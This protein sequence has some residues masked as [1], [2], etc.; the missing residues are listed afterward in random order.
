MI[1]IYKK[2]KKRNERKK[3]E[4]R[5][6][7]AGNNE[8][9]VTLTEDALEAQPRVV[10]KASETAP[11]K[12]DS[13]PENK[14][15]K[16]KRRVYRW[17]LIL[18]L[19]G[20]F[21]LQ[22]LDTTIIA[23]ALPYIAE[24]FD[25]VSQLNWIISAFNLTSAAS[26][27]FWAQLSDLFGRHNTL[28]AAIF[29]MVI[30]SAICTGSPTSTFSVLLLGRALQGVGAAGVNI[31]VRTILADGVSLSEFAVNW[32]IF[33]LVAGIGFSIGPVIGGYLT[34]ASWRWCF[35]INLPIGV[36]AMIL[37]VFILRKDLQGPQ[38]LPELE[39][40]DLSTVSRRFMARIATIDF[41]GQMLFLWGF[42]LLILALTWAGGNYAWDSAAVLAPIIIGAILSIAWVVYE[43]FMVPGAFMARALPRQKAMMPWELI[44]QR[45]IGLLFLINFTMGVSMFA[46][47]Y[48][49]DLYFAL[50][51][52]NSSSKAGTSLLYFLPGLGAGVYLAMFSSNIWPRQT[53]PTLIVGSLAS[54]VGITVLAWAVKAAQTNVIY[55]MM[56]LVGFGIGSRMNPA[57]LHGLAYF[58]AMTAQISC[59]VS[60][61]LPFGGLVGLTIMSTVFTNKSGVDQSDPKQGIKWAF[62]AMIPFMWISVILTTF[63]G[64]VW[65]K[66][67]GGHEVVNGAYLWSFLTRKKLT[68]ESR[69]RGEDVRPVHD[70]KQRDIEMTSA[71]PVSGRIDGDEEITR[72]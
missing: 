62:I 8:P 33:A 64:N 19:F 16:R 68:R 66:K 60:F 12:E 5:Q 69:D 7:E 17:K 63:L 41:G 58:P 59:L 1:L 57:S 51:E 22:S 27:F 18:G 46:V 42:G 14:A 72:L 38:P 39:G 43:R 2:I 49:M 11:E 4:Q 32:T 10:P 53:L 29:T 67:D 35:A 45:D 15:A 61:A 40:R 37:V 20:P 70:E 21:C 26:L 71:Q 23:S 13:S 52:G 25:Q 65:I 47:M 6:Q 34:T 48:F 24:D 54:A 30:G 9:A 28:Q 55:G 56:A 50:V 3:L 44:S 31:S 36:A